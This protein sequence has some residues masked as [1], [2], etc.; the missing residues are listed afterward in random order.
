MRGFFVPFA[1]E[2]RS[3]RCWFECRSGSHPR[4]GPARTSP[5]F[6]C[7]DKAYHVPL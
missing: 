7:A 2:I 6:R 5:L 3:C 1:D 4:R